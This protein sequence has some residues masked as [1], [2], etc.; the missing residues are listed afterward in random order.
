M[1]AAPPEERGF[2]LIQTYEPTLPE[3][4]T[5]FFDATRD[6]RG[7]LYFGNLS[8]VLVFDGAWWRRIEVGKAITAFRVKGG[9]NGRVGV[10][11]VDEIGYLAPDG[12]A[13]LRYVS[14][15]NLLPPG[16]RKLGQVLYIQPVG[17][18]FAF[19]TSQS[20]YECGQVIRNA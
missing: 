13:T 20:H 9:E 16:Q 2:P 1:G 11:G 10:G 19:L 4:S 3:A 6:S 14:L 17:Q 8:G 15:I 5:Q 18:G 7:I 12:H